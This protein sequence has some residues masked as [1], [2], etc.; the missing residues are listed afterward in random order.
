MGWK[1]YWKQFVIYSTVNGFGFM[2]ISKDL[3]ETM[4]WIVCFILAAVFTVR[5]IEIEIEVY[6][7]GPVKTEV[8]MKELRPLIL[9]KVTMCF[10]VDLTKL[11][12]KT[13][14]SFGFDN[15]SIKTVPVVIQNF[16]ENHNSPKTLKRNLQALGSLIC[17]QMN[18]TLLSHK[19]KDSTTF[20]TSFKDICSPDH[21]VWLGP[22]PDFFEDI[23]CLD[24]TPEGKHEISYNTIYDKVQIHWKTHPWFTEYSDRKVGARRPIISLSGGPVISQNSENSFRFAATKSSSVTLEL[25]AKLKKVGKCG[26]DEIFTELCVLN[27]TAALIQSELQCIPYPF[28]SFISVNQT[29]PVCPVNFTLQSVPSNVQCPSQCIEQCNSELF[30]FVV[31]SDLTLDQSGK[32]QETAEIQLLVNHFNHQFLSEDYIYTTRALIANIAGKFKNASEYFQIMH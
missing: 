4:F 19:Q 32:I 26:S 6:Q 30:V 21:V 5:G 17:K 31:D 15:S 11:K 22:E 10:P 25:N 20:T 28:V 2:Q 1:N 27:C 9:D 18:L 8:S 13:L 24:L 7:D 16:L 23:L 3:R 12:Y 14:S 29:T